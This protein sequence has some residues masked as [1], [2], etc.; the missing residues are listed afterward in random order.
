MRRTGL[1]LTLAAVVICFSRIYVGTHYLSDVLGG[2]LTACIAS[3][4]V[5]WLYRAGSRIDATLT[6]IF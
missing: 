5:G 4:L 2:M 3:L 6:R 1:W